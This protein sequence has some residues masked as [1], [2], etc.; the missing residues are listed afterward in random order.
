MR[1]RGPAPSPAAATPAIDPSLSLLQREERPED[2]H[3]SE[4]PG[5]ALETPV[6]KKMKFDS[7]PDQPIVSARQA[8]AAR[9]SR[10]ELEG[11]NHE[12]RTY[13]REFLDIQQQRDATQQALTEKLSKNL[14]DATAVIDRLQPRVTGTPAL[15]GGDSPMGSIPSVSQSGVSSLSGAESTIS[16]TAIRAPV[17]TDF[18]FPMAVFPLVN[19]SLQAAVQ[20][21]DEGAP[22]LGWIG[23]VGSPNLGVLPVVEQTANL[24]V[25]PIVEQPGQVP[26]AGL[27]LIVQTIPPVLN[28]S[29][30]VVNVGA[31]A[32][33]DQQPVGAHSDLRRLVDRKELLKVLPNFSGR[34]GTPWDGNKDLCISG[35]VKTFEIT[36]STHSVPKASYLELLKLRLVGAAINFFHDDVNQ[37]LSLGSDADLFAEY[38]KAKVIFIQNFLPP[39]FVKNLRNPVM[40]MA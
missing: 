25:L 9:P 30:S 4:L 28:L 26:A 31:S 24:G 35:F 16:L 12:L 5:A 34:I 19:G 6:G 17:A 29:T 37:R 23:N 22:G 2:G 36:L 13:M 11:Q 7:G 18:P 1:W 38:L 15:N 3:G 8:S 39:M 10:R 33:P 32:R 21:E 14:S 20:H 27:P 40:L